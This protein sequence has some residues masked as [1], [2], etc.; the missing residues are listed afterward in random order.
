MGELFSF[1][2]L[3]REVSL[4]WDYGKGVGIFIAPR[5][6]FILPSASCL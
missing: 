5:E 3:I 6:N 4:I 1:E 2:F